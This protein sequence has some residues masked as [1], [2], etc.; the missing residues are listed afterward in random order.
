[1]SRLTFIGHTVPGL[2]RITAYELGLRGL[3]SGP[4]DALTGLTERMIPGRRFS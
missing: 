4:I 2:E 3:T 1:M